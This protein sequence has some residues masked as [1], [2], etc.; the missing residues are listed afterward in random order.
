MTSHPVPGV[1]R[2]RPKAS[3]DLPTYLPT[4]LSRLYFG[5]QCNPTAPAAQ[6]TERPADIT[7][8]SAAE[9]TIYTEAA[10]ANLNQRSLPMPLGTPPLDGTAFYFESR[11]IELRER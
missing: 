11:L 5:Y 2:T 1:R 8:V 4:Y 10:T 6:A 3:R 7:E 9:D